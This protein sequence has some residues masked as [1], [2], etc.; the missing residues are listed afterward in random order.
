MVDMQGLMIAVI[1]AGKDIDDNSSILANQM[2]KTY[3]WLEADK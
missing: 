1:T 3:L 2:E